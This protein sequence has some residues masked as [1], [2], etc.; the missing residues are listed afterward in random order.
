MSA[1]RDPYVVV[2]F[3]ERWFVVHLATRTVLA[4]CADEIAAVG[5][6]SVSR[7]VGIDQ[8]DSNGH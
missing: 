5:I 3:G 4:E 6:A 7:V 2:S 1:Q 8:E